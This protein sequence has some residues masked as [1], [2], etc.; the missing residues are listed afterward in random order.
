MLFMPAFALGESASCPAPKVVE[1][2]AVAEGWKAYGNVDLFDKPAITFQ[3]MRI[4]Y[5]YVFCLYEVGN[6]VVR[7]QLVGACKSLSGT[8]QDQGPARLCVRPDPNACVAEC[9]PGTR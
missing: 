5:E 8:W 7:L 3:V 9:P 2:N 6:G 4:N 1:L